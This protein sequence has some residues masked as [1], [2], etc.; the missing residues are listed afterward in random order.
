[1]NDH[2]KKNWV[3]LCSRASGSA[4]RTGFVPSWYLLFC[5]PQFGSPCRSRDT[6]F[7]GWCKGRQ[8]PL[9]LELTR[10]GLYCGPILDRVTWQVER[11]RMEGLYISCRDIALA[12]RPTCCS[13][14][15]RGRTLLIMNRLHFS[16]EDLSISRELL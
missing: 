5:T 7:Q 9:G 3:K 2:F 11:T 13:F 1:M 10:P 15:P 14:R 6:S 4:I 12:F 16:T 8:H